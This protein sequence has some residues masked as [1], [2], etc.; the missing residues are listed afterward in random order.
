MNNTERTFGEVWDIIKNTL[1]FER[2]SQKLIA[3][4]YPKANNS[5][6]YLAR[7]KESYDFEIPLDKF[8]NA[9]IETPENLLFGFI[10]IQGTIQYSETKN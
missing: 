6:T 2:T 7:I 9:K 3:L 5:E 8:E 10:M 1:Y 4:E